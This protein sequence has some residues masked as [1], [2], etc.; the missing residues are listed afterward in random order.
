[1]PFLSNANVIMEMYV[2][3]NV[4]NEFLEQKTRSGSACH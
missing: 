1:M 2:Y 4:V 3:V